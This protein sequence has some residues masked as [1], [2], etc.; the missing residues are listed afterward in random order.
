MHPNIPKMHSKHFPDTFRKVKQFQKIETVVVDSKRTY[1]L[2][3]LS[4]SFFEGIK[5]TWFTDSNT[6]WYVRLCKFNTHTWDAQAK[7]WLLL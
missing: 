1:L 7:P 5:W 2:T 4:G 3:T 6:H